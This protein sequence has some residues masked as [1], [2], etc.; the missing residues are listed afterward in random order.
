MGVQKP[1]SHM[2]KPRGRVEA[3]NNPAQF[4]DFYE[5]I[6]GVLRHQI[7]MILVTRIGQLLETPPPPPER[8]PDGSFIIR[9]KTAEEL[10]KWLK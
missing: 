4:K 7:L 3:N 10:R 5:F 2:E 1:Q 8:G 9:G 6:E